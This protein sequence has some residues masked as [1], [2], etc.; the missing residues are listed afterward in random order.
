[1]TNT[2]TQTRWTVGLWLLCGLIGFAVLFGR[3]TYSARDHLRLGER[4]HT[5]GDWPGA[6]RELGRA[7]RYQ[8]PGNVYATRAA[9][10]LLALGKEAEGGGPRVDRE[11]A[12]RAYQELRAAL[13]GARHFTTPHAELLHEAN[14]RLAALW[15]Q[16]EG[17]G[18]AAQRW[19]AQKLAPEQAPLPAPGWSLLAVIGAALLVGGMAGLLRRGLNAEGRVASGAAVARWTALMLLGLGAM[20]LGLW[21]A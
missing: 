5:G 16:E 20:L 9:Q 14:T 4:A 11:V 8:A 12:K 1:M 7:A 3:V 21:R 10:A 15:V 19:H 6:V 2:T 18:E 13:L 17:S